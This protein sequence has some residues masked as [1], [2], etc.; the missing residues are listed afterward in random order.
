[1]AKMAAWIMKAAVASAAVAA[2][3]RVRARR[4]LFVPSRDWSLPAG[5][6][7]GRFT[8]PFPFYGFRFSMVLF[9]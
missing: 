8:A 6:S 7:I 9:L 1:M 5:G 3:T 2:M 4:P